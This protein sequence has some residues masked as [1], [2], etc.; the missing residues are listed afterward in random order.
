MKLINY[1]S[2]NFEDAAMAAIFAKQPFSVSIRGWKRHVISKALPIFLSS[3]DS[4]RRRANNLKLIP[5]AVI[6]P[7]F[8]GVCVRASFEKL[9]P[10]WHMERDTLVV[11]FS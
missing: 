4:E 8:W 3:S 9:L 5:L 1:H 2:R 11:R 6:T 7:L 10:S